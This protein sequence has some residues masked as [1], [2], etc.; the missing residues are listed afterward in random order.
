MKSFLCCFFT[1]IMLCACKKKNFVDINK[2]LKVTIKDSI[3]IPLPTAIIADVNKNNLLVYNMTS[4]EIGVFN[5]KDKILKSFNKFGPGQDEFMLSLMPY[6]LNFVGD[7]LI[8]IGGT[9]HIMT[10][11]FEGNFVEKLNIENENTSAPLSNFDILNDSI[12]IGLRKPQGDIRHQD[13]YNGHHKLLLKQN[14]KNNNQE[15]FGSFP[16]EGSDLGNKDFYYPYPYVYY[17]ALDNVNN[18]YALINSNDSHLFTFDVNTNRIVKKLQLELDYYNRLEKPYKLNSG[19]D[20]SMMD[21]YTNSMIMGYFKGSDFDYVVYNQGKTTEFMAD[22][23][24]HNTLGSSD[25][26]PLDFDIWLH[27]LSNDKKVFKDRKI[28][29]KFGA[30][31]HFYSSKKVIFSKKANAKDDLEGNTIYY[32]CDLNLEL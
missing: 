19:S 8:G 30:P 31:S 15:L 4:S 25:A 3:T 22:Y 27:T 2:E 18:T 5:I 14:L 21:L 29:T 9:N 28:P 17:N 16:L 20:E 26:E 23:M 6:S 7:T 13:Y 10:Y 1:L 11:D 12:F 24:R 32:F